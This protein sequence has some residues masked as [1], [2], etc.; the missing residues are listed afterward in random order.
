M[1]AQA[2]VPTSGLPHGHPPA[3]A[4]PL[5]LP[6]A[7]GFEAWFAQALAAASPAADPHL[8]SGP[9]DYGLWGTT[10]DAEGKLNL[11]E[12]AENLRA[13]LPAL[14][15]NLGKACR[16]H[17][18]AVPPMLRLEAQISLQPTLPFDQRAQALQQLF[19][20]TPGLVRQ[21]RRLMAGFGF[22]R[23]SDAL[24]AYQ[25]ALGKLGPSRLAA[26]LATLGDVHASPTLAIAFDGQT[27]WPEEA[28][29]EHWRPLASLAQLDRELLALAG[30]SHRAPEPGL[31]LSTA[32]D[33]HRA[34]FDKLNPR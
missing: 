17:S 10:P 24:R 30:A 27:C 2:T 21:F 1:R 32:L 20:A 7:A 31:P 6:A 4:P 33:P 12:V 19:D 28:S 3:A 22:V 25:R 13:T 29:G 15:A 23:C 18:L 14:A 11:T 5:R 34:R 8:L 26:V 16:D 9:A